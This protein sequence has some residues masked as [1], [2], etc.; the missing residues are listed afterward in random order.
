M[1][2]DD[3]INS[4]IAHFLYQQVYMPSS[5]LLCVKK[6]R[7]TSRFVLQVPPRAYYPSKELFIVGNFI[8]LWGSSRD[9]DCPRYARTLMLHCTRRGRSIVTLCSERWMH[10]PHLAS[11]V[12]RPFSPE[13]V[14]PITFTNICFAQRA[15]YHSWSAR[16]ILEASPAPLVLSSPQGPDSLPLLCRC[17]A[18][19]SPTAWHPSASWLPLCSMVVNRRTWHT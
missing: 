18:V 4:V 15:L 14:D 10:V 16:Q 1:V 7:T 3:K 13:E 19:V 9:S 17:L 6:S 11:H 5:R 2:Q 12:V 8:S